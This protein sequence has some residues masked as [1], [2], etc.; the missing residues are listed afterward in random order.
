LVIDSAGY[1][2]TNNHVIDGATTITVTVVSTGK[3]YA[4]TVVGT[5]PTNDIAVLHLANASGLQTATFGDSDTVKVSDKVTGVGN[6]GGA[7]G[8]PSAAA[9]TVQALNQTITA[10]DESG[11]SAERLSGVI[12]TD[13]PIQAGD[14]GG[15]LFNAKDQVVGINTAA[16]TNGQAAGFAIPINK[17]LSI[18]QQIRKG[19]ETSSI[20]IGY[21]AFLGVSVQNSSG[22]GAL[23]GDVVA[24]LPAAKAG[25]VGGD[26]ITK[27]DNTK[28]G[29]AAELKTVLNK[30]QPGDKVTIT[31]LD[32]AGA[33]HQVTVTLIAG[34]AD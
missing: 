14:S 5:S 16:S 18:A 8:T 3:R 28:I 30:Y 10:S 9:G 13:A 19:I 2:L 32:A 26:T 20:H 33:S 22:T 6:A 17:A 31:Y 7:G 25:I 1:I 15:P 4:A 21:P 27:V 23:I 34:P 12:A 29:A 11:A 24:G